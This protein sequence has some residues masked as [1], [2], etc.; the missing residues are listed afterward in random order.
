MADTAAFRSVG[1]FPFCYP[2]SDQ[3][4]SI[5]TLEDSMH[6][7]WLLKAAT[8]SAEVQFT[9]VCPSGSSP[10]EA[11]F[12]INCQWNKPPYERICYENHEAAFLDQ[13]N[14]FAYPFT[15]TG[16]DNFLSFATYDALP[17]LPQCEPNSPDYYAFGYFNTNGL[18][19]D[20][21]EI[22]FS[23]TSKSFEVQVKGKTLTFYFVLAFPSDSPVALGWSII[24]ASGS[25]QLWQPG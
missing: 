23:Y 1:Y 17:P 15:K 18:P 22:G 25:L 11:T 16:S 21:G 14:F 3:P 9:H 12:S 19:P 5:A 24:S 7:W 10:I 6:V 20:P 13:V 8:F 4:S 2:S